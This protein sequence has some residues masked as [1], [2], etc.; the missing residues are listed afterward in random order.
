MYVQSFRTQSISEEL[1]EQTL[2]FSICQTKTKAIITD[3]GFVFR[4]EAFE[5]AVFKASP[6]HQK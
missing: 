2:R 4:Q 1:M 6:Y 3:R 5:I